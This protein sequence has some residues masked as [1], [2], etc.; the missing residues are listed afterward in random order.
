MIHNKNMMLSIFALD[1]TN[2]PYKAE[3]TRN[4]KRNTNILLVLDFN[5]LLIADFNTPFSVPDR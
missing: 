4:I 2:L 3:N 5:S 1:N